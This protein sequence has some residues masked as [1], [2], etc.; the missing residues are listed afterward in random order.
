MIKI[1]KRESRL[2]LSIIIGIIVF[3]LAGLDS[4]AQSLFIMAA[5]NFL[6]A[7]VN[8]A[9]LFF[10]NE[11]KPGFNI[12]LLFI[13]ASFAF[14]I[15]FDYYLNNKKLLP[16]AWLLVGVFYILLILKTIKD[17]KQKQTANKLS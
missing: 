3:F 2:R 1:F 15:A 17:N 10:I 11:N 7:A 5:S 16:I 13:N 6:L 9:S 8:A 14:F 12:L 4:I